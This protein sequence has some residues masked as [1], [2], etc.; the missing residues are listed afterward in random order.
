MKS[1]ATSDDSP[2]PLQTPTHTVDEFPLPPTDQEMAPLHFNNNFP[3]LHDHSTPSTDK[4]KG[5]AQAMDDL[6]M[7]FDYNAGSAQ[8]DMGMEV[9][10]DE[11]VHDGFI[12]GQKCQSTHTCCP[13]L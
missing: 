11:L 6:M 3:S 10:E 1:T 5:H 13:L 9:V 4:G 12:G 7:E 8:G 2:L